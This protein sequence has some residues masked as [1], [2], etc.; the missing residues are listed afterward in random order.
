MKVQI[1]GSRFEGVMPE[2]GECF[3]VP[4][5]SGLYI[6]VF[7]PQAMKNPSEIMAASLETGQIH[8]FDI[9]TK[10]RDGF[11][12]IVPKGGAMLFERVSHNEND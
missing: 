4:N 11:I 9:C 3:K 6:R 1:V 8:I 7:D 2:Q 10:N 12:K 5:G